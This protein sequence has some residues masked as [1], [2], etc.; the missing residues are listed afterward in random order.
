MTQELNECLEKILTLQW[1]PF[2]D[3]ILASGSC[4]KSVRVWDIKNVRF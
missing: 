2:F 3:Y 4:D 1:H